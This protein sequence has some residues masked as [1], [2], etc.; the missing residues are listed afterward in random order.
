MSQQH[1]KRERRMERRK[2]KSQ[3]NRKEK[4]GRKKRKKEAVRKVLKER[5]SGREAYRTAKCD[6]KER[7]E[8]ENIRGERSRNGERRPQRKPVE[9]KML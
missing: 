8:T 5:K 9:T 4:T 6:E 1:Q 3:N 7:W 2:E